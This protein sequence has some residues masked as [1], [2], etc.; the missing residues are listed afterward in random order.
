MQTV[1][2]LGEHFLNVIKSALIK[3]PRQALSV[4]SIT[5]FM[6]YSAIHKAADSLATGR[7]HKATSWNHP[8]RVFQPTAPIHSL[9]DIFQWNGGTVELYQSNYGTAGNREAGGFVNSAANCEELFCF[10]TV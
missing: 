3:N 5:F 7:S 9:L 4:I 10:I 6:A 1:K 2:V 8:Q